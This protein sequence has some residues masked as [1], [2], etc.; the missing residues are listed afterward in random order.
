MFTCVC[1]WTNICQHAVPQVNRSQRLSLDQRGQSSK[2]G[3]AVGIAQIIAGGAFWVRHHAK[4]VHAFVCHASDVGYSSIGVGPT[5]DF[6]CGIA[7]LEENL[8]VILQSFQA[9]FLDE[10]I[11]LSVCDG[12]GN[13]GVHIQR[14]GYR[15]LAGN[16]LE[17]DILANELAAFV[18][19]QCSGQKSCFA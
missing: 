6:A 5:V 4:Y 1:R 13:R 15:S 2:D 14:T 10:I 7:V 17:V 11:A 8:V 3:F 18:V 16:R 19:Q 9:V 12:N